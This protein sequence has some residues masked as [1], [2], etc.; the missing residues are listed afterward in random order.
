[1]KKTTLPDY[2]Q[3]GNAAT[4]LKA[5]LKQ[6]NYNTIHVLVDENTHKHCFSLLKSQHQVIQVKSGEVNKS[7]K[8]CEHIWSALEQQGAGRKSLLI[9]LGGGLL[10]DLGGFAASLYMRGIDFIHI[11][12]TLIAQGD[13]CIGSKTGV[14]YMHYKNHLGTFAQPA[15]VLIDPRFLDTLDERE[16]RSGYAELLKHG[17]IADAPL[18][19]ALDNPKKKITSELVL[20][21]LAC[22]NKIVQ[23]DPKEQNLRKLLNF[24]HTVGHAIESAF[25]KKGKP[26]LH[27]EAVAAGMICEAYLSY[28]H[29]GLK[30]KALE[31]ICQ[32]IEAFIQLPEITEKMKSELINYMRKDKKN[33]D[34]RIN[35]TLLD[36][37]GKSTIDNHLDELSILNALNFYA[38]RK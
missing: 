22:K 21:S 5:W 7:L 15:C 38:S 28:F 2:F 4:L 35:F 8:S 14:N 25:I 23:K 9:N 20:H 17:L 33:K 16:L 3:V 27:G 1:M 13:S 11:P 24:G 37:I 10:C 29:C 34:E 12:T 6:K 36:G 26:I 32:K 19:R 18:W 31:D 30:K